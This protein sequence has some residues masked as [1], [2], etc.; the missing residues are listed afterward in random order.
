MKN[1]LITPEEVFLLAS[2]SLFVVFEIGLAGMCWKGYAKGLTSAEGAV[3]SWVAF[4]LAGFV[5]YPNTLIPP[6][7]IPP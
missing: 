2:V 4:S 1:H 6:R 5:G 7:E 3:F